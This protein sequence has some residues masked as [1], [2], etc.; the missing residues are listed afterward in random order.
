MIPLKL[1]RRL[2]RPV[3]DFA[4]GLALFSGIAA[5]GW[6]E[7]LPNGADWIAGAAHANRLTAEVPTGMGLTDPGFPAY[8]IHLVAAGP[9]T[10]SRQLI[11]LISLAL[12]FSTLVAVNIWFARHVRRLHAVGRR[13][14]RGS[15]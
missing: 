9:G 13:G 8:V 6:A 1:S 14:L 7:R 5:S 10:D 4:A 11:A 2:S 3:R 15:H 12:A